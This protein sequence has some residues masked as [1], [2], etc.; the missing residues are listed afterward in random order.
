METQL[1]SSQPPDGKRPRGRRLQLS[2]AQMGGGTLGA[3]AEGGVE[4][5]G[6]SR[7]AVEG[8]E[9]LLGGGGRDDFTEQWLHRKHQHTSSH[10]HAHTDA[11]PQRYTD[12]YKYIH[13]AHTCICAHTH[14]NTHIYAP[15][16]TQTLQ[17][18]WLAMARP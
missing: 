10:T 7:A 1:R 17:T 4:L 12:I 9:N 14:I 6:G 8:D 11:H 18:A 15:M 16:H 5:R 2:H 3:R 13:I